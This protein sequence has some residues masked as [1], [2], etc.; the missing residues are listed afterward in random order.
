MVGPTFILCHEIEITRQISCKAKVKDFLYKT[1]LFVPNIVLRNLG[2]AG[3]QL[4]LAML[5]QWRDFIQNIIYFPCITILPEIYL[6]YLILP[7]DQ[8]VCL[9][10]WKF[11]WFTQMLC[12]SVI[13]TQLKSSE[14]NSGLLLGQTSLC[15]PM[16]MPHAH[17]TPG[18][19]PVTIRFVLCLLLTQ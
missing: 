6:S 3:R 1:W 10:W 13:V 17:A 19:C 16:P 14:R 4:P 5:S 2:V 15:H 11:C 9:S 8:E 18:G 12:Q 7:H